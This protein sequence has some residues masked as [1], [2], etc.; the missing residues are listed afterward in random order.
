MHISVRKLTSPTKS[1]IYYIPTV[2]LFRTKMG[3]ALSSLVP[4]SDAAV[5]KV[6]D[7]RP[8][9]IVCISHF[10]HSSHL[11]SKKL[12][13]LTYSLSCVLLAAVNDNLGRIPGRF[14]IASKRRLT[15]DYRGSGKHD[16][17]MHT[18]DVLAASRHW[19]KQ[20]PTKN[21]VPTA[22]QFAGIRGHRHAET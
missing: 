2:V 20:I 6:R 10:C 19:P 5:T 1:E 22:V 17:Q 4:D 13:L 9:N 15:I 8:A 3:H 16:Y 21:A 11:L 12:L 7:H 14:A 18:V